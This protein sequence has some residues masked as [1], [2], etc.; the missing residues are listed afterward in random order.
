M[1]KAILENEFTISLTTEAHLDLELRLAMQLCPLLAQ[2]GWNVLKAKGN[3]FITSDRPVALFWDDYA[4]NDP[5]G[6]GLIGTRLLLNSKPPQIANSGDNGMV[7]KN[8]GLI[9]S[10][11]KSC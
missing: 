10:S 5:I 3:K 1:R 11:T 8:S 7:V 9:L 4:K 2:R 6:L